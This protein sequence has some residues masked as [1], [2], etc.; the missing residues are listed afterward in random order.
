ME[1]L[2]EIKV[3]V[4]YPTSNSLLTL[5]FVWISAIYFGRCSNKYNMSALMQQEKFKTGRYFGDLLRYLRYSSGFEGD[6][7]AIRLAKLMKVNRSTVYSWEKMDLPSARIDLEKLGRI[8]GVEEDRLR[9]PYLSSEQRTQSKITRKGEKFSERPL[10][11]ISVSDRRERY[12]EHVSSI[13]EQC[14]EYLREF[15]ASAG[16]DES[17]LHW[18]MVELQTR[19]PLDKW[20][21]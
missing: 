8:L 2:A 7:G 12:R 10:N 1:A 13:E 20:L 4:F 16:G 3:E 18:T 6:E 15:L 17:K 14:V 21:G 5:T 19:F 9:Y 11:P